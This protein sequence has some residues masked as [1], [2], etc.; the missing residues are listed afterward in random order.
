MK[1]KI[2]RKLVRKTNKSLVETIIAGKKNASWEIV[3]HKISIPRRKRL[4]LNLNEIDEKSKEG[5]I[6]VVPG[7][8]LSKGQITKK[9][10]I[11]ALGYSESAMKKLKTSKTEFN[12]I[13]EEIK[14][15]PEAKKIKL[16]KIK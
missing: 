3:A 10:K 11:S 16:L 1:T 6:V 7:K 12:F 2:E 4:D 5:D 14:S 13:N 9:I 15:N 8:V